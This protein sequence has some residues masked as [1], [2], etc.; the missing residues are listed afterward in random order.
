MLRDRA[1]GIDPRGLETSVVFRHRGALGP[2]LSARVDWLRDQGM[3]L[4]GDQED[5]I[6]V[7]AQA[8]GGQTGRLEPG[9][10]GKPER[11]GIQVG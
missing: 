1:R 6:I 9:R 8:P 4:D 5:V 2:I 10:R 11:A 7:R 3:L